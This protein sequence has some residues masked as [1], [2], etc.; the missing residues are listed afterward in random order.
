MNHVI[1]HC[2]GGVCPPECIYQTMGIT[3]ECLS[4]CIRVGRP[5]PYVDVSGK[6]IR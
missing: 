6:T 2:R 1:I 4:E 3:L 5:H